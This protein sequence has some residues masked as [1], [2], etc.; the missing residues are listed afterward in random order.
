MKTVVGYVV[1]AVVVLLLLGAEV[2][3]ILQL[4]FLSILVFSAFHLM[5]RQRLPGDFWGSLGL[6]IFGP[7]V[8]MA[9]ITA[10]LS[11]LPHASAVDYCAWGVVLL[12][13]FLVA[14]GFAYRRY[15]R[16]RNEPHV[17]TRIRGSERE[18][19]L[20][21]QDPDSKGMFS[22]KTPEAGDDL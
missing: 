8:L 19:I 4:V 13:V 5:L 3:A 9:V 6:L 14:L 17:G 11:Q 22:E 2:N 16:G 12:V 7:I 20:P 10:L 21:S 1:C 18:F 15:N